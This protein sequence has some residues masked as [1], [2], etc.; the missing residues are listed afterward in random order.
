MAHVCGIALQAKVEYHVPAAVQGTTRPRM[1][2]QHAQMLP[3]AVL[4]HTGQPKQGAPP[5]TVCVLRVQQEI[6]VQQGPQHRHPV[7]LEATV[8][9][10][11]AIQQRV[12]QGAT[13][14]MHPFRSPAQL[15][16]IVHQGS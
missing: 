11:L 13:V 8:Q 7:L 3:T 10:D 12:L 1:I 2:L 15:E 6:T 5:K 14:Q 4:D 16:A 9:Q